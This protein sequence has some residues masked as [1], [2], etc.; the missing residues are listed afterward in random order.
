MMVL[1][2]TRVGPTTL[3]D[4]SQRMVMCWG[5]EA[6]HVDVC[7]CPAPPVRERDAVGAEKEKRRRREGEAATT[8]TQP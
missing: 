1:L 3:G 2:C 7:V 6:S 4:A 5:A 8:G